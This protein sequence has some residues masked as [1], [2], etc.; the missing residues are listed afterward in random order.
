MMGAMTH[1]ARIERDALCATFT[2]VGPEAPTLCSPW[3]TAD[4]AAHLV[5]RERRPDLAPGIWLPALASRT[6]RGMQEYAAKPWPELVDLVRS[7]PPV[8]SP[9]RVAAVDD[10]VNFVELF[11][12]HEDVLRGDETPGPRRELSDR[13]SRAVWKALVRSARL[14]FRR[15]P[16]SVVLETP[17]GQRAQAR[18]VTGTGTVVLRGAPAELLLAASGRRRVAQ[19]EEVGDE[20]AIAA[21]WSAPTGLA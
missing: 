16:A 4:L 12:H 7:G 15:S 2:D 13:E 11:I 5:V 17:D 19:L 1:L 18:T 6:E 3:S 21:L 9:A 20:E 10:T 8:W 14:M